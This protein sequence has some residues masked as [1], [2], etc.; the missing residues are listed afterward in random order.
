MRRAALP[1]L[2]ALVLPTAAGAQGIVHASRP[3]G[4]SLAKWGA[5]LYA[6]NCLSCHGPNGQGQAP[7]GPLGAGGISGAGPSL[8][9]VGA[10]SADFYLRTGSM[11][12]PAPSDQPRRSKVQF[13]EREVDALVAYVASL[14]TGPP[15]P[16][17]RPA[18]GSVAQGLQ[19]FTQHCAGCHQVV[20]AGGYLKGAVAP[21]LGQATATQ[22][23]EA[24]RIGPYLMPS[25]SPKAIS[26]RQLDSIVAYVQYT[27]HSDD[28]GGW[29]LGHIGPI[30][31][32][33]VTWLIA[34]AV[35]VGVCIV[36]GERLRRE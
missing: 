8:R 11:P 28:P 13:S 17:P 22:I 1:F 16:E 34:S 35:L 10:L 3:P 25:F 33:L 26:D 36:I 15:V 31:E 9:G 18:R 27:K 29:P 20:A 30:P 14:G 2:L 23:A 24:V 7:N 12:L 4:A 5:G 6:A 32:G 21:S 19:L